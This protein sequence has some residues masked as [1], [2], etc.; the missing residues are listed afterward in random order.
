LHARAI[1]S[2]L[3]R[4]GALGGDSTVVAKDEKEG[5]RKKLKVQVEVFFR[6]GKSTAKHV[7]EKKKTFSPRSRKKRSLKEKSQHNL[8]KLHALDYFPC[9]KKR[10]KGGGVRRNRRAYS[11]QGEAPVAREPTKKRATPKRKETE[12]VPMRRRIHPKSSE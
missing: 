8:K 2:L 1:E 11:R 6:P 10:T 9:P 3:R 12:G 5:H 4:R 7:K